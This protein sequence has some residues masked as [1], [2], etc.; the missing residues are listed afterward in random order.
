MWLC[1][2]TL[3]PMVSSPFV[4]NEKGYKM[5]RMLISRSRYFYLPILDPDKKLLILRLISGFSISI[6][7]IINSEG[8]LLERELN[9]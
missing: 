8:P 6:P 1:I 9:R 7:A 5:S 4:N 2:D 3:F